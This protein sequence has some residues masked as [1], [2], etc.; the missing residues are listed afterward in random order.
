MRNNFEYGEKNVKTKEPQIEEPFTDL[1][2]DTNH[3]LVILELPGI[4]DIN[5]L[6]GDRIVLIQGVNIFHFFEKKIEVP[7]TVDKTKT[8]IQFNHG[9][10]EIHFFE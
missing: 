8:Q 1:F 3:A 7:F 10:A 5:I 2:I 4:T 9:I 6:Y